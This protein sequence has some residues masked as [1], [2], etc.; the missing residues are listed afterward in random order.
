MALDHE[1][2]CTDLG[3]LFYSIAAADGRVRSEE[4][5]ELIRSIRAPWFAQENLRHAPGTDAAHCITDGFDYA[6]ENE[7]P[8][9]EAFARFGD[10]VRRKPS[11]LDEGMR[12]VIFQIAVSVASAFASRNKAELTMLMRLQ[13]LFQHY[14]AVRV[15]GN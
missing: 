5:N 10:R 11:D 15:Q 13:Q 2:L 8:K 7:I 1:Q 9:D 4:R 3:Y 12:H 14:P 6:L